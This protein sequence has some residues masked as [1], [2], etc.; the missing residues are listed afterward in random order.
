M[1]GLNSVPSNGKLYANKDMSSF[2]KY[3]PSS[4]DN[5]VPW[6]ARYQY[7]GQAVPATKTT[8]RIS[9]KNGANFQQN[10]VIR[11]E[12]PAQGYINP[13]NTTLAFDVALNRGDVPDNGGSAGDF[14]R[15]QNNIQ[16]IFQRVRLL[17]GS[18]PIEDIIDYNVITRG[19][20]EW[21]AQPGGHADQLSINE[22]IGNISYGCTGDNTGPAVTSIM[23]ARQLF[24][25]GHDSINAGATDNAAPYVPSE[26]GTFAGNAP[27]ATLKYPTRRY[28][29]QL[30]LGLFNQDKLIPV[31]FM[32]S[33][34]AIEITLASNVSCLYSIRSNPNCSYEVQNVTLL[35]EILEF[36]AAYDAMFLKGLKQGGVP[37]KF[38]T[39][40]NFQFNMPAA[41]SVNVQIQERAR[42]VKSIFAMQRIG[43]DA[44]ATDSG[45]SLYS[46]S[47]GNT[48]QQ[49]QFRIGGRYYPAAPVKCNVDAGTGAGS[50][51]ASEA[52][53]ELGKAL[54]TLGDYRLSTA[55]TSPRWGYPIVSGQTVDQLA[56]DGY[57]G[58]RAV[59]TT[60]ITAN[61]TA[62]NSINL[63]AGFF[64]QQFC[65]AQSLVTTD[66]GEISGLNTE[67]QSDIILSAT[68][69]GTQTAGYVL[70]VF[71]YFD[72][73]LVLRENNVVE[74][75]Q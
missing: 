30:G 5:I 38:Q 4:E 35:P 17:Y 36:D 48:L 71:T 62:V 64:S 45:A 49:F 24:I 3:Y 61:Q 15:F 59:N 75:I 63:N 22:G 74:L 47:A 8:P 16:S 10:Q 23:H 6:N 51:G 18:T 40:H 70:E 68:W 39:W 57:Y 72:C 21:T 12:F 33:Q 44:Y 20:T 50:N 52:F 37:I 27:T 32:A 56:K 66:G 25:H 31:K 2:A 11:L 43:P 42:S 46:S 67:E 55:L 53:A 69:S 9:P 14:V 7:P 60:G 54:H 28:T 29:V 41:T 34:L 73:L 13:R 65:M 19:L 1:H 26:F 58:L